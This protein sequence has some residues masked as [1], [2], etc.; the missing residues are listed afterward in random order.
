MCAFFLVEDG[1][2]PCFTKRYTTGY[3]QSLIQLR[4]SVEQHDSQ[5]AML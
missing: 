5:C 2:N 3:L 4:M 1:H